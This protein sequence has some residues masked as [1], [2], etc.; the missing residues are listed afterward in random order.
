MVHRAFKSDIDSD[1]T[2]VKGNVSEEEKLMALQIFTHFVST[3]EKSYGADVGQRLKLAEVNVSVKDGRTGYGE[4]TFEV[5]VTK[6]NA[7]GVDG[8]GVSQ[9]MNLIWHQP[10]RVY[11][12]VPWSYQVAV[13]I[14]PNLE[15]I[16]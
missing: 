11:V 2:H 6:G 3:K 9:S 13:V 12:A 8:T 7:I 1:I 4:T 10:A 5:V 14:N 16:N 15:A